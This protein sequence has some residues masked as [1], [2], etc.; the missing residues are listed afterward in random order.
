ME[1]E[2]GY[3]VFQ[4]QNCMLQTLS[5][6]QKKKEG[7]HCQSDGYDWYSEVI[8]TIALW[9]LFIYSSSS[10]RWYH[11][12]TYFS[13]LHLH[14]GSGITS[15]P[16]SAPVRLAYKAYKYTETGVEL[17]VT[18]SFRSL[19]F[20]SRYWCL[21]LLIIHFDLLASLWVSSEPPFPVACLSC[22]L[23]YSSTSSIGRTSHNSSAPHLGTFIL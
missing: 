3:S 9:D 11:K 4:D 18:S 23:P 5:K 13:V 8:R 14:R 16:E 21:V 12:I 17:V 20:H 22:T 2:D 19:E 7:P 15:I 6:M 10:H 1:L